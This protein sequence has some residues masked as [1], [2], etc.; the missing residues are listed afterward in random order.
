MTFFQLIMHVL[1][2]LFI[3][4]VNIMTFNVLQKVSKLK[5]TKVHKL[6]TLMFAYR[7]REQIEWE[8]ILWNSWSTWGV[9][10]FYGHYEA[11][12]FQVF[13]YEFLLQI[14]LKSFLAR[15]RFVF[16][17]CRECEEFLNSEELSRIYFGFSF[18]AVE[19]MIMCF[20]VWVRH[21]QIIIKWIL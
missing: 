5:I 21:I 13:T 16:V 17:L 1:L 14:N 4:K 12:N 8:N 6:I 20:C 3:T 2:F 11:L 15:Q 7:R 19:W 9:F 10:A 18:F